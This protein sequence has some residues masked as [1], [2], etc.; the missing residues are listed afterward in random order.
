MIE[1]ANGALISPI[2]LVKKNDAEWS[3]CIDFRRLNAVSQHD[4]YPL[5]KIDENFDAL[6]G[7]KCFSPSD[8]I[9]GYWRAPLDRPAQE[10]SALLYSPGCGSG[11]CSI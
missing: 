5:P 2:V 8:L 9:T 1:L 3:F 11:R 10:Q 7:S 6:P 4:V